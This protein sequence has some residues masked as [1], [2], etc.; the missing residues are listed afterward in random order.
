MKIP[1]VP[2]HAGAKAVGN[3]EVSVAGVT[4]TDFIFHSDFNGTNVPINLQRSVVVDALGVDSIAGEPA[5]QF[6]GL[7]TDARRKLISVRYDGRVF[8]K[9]YLSDIRRIYNVARP[10]SAS[11]IYPDGQYAIPVPAELHGENVLLQW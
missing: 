5:K 8:C 1:F 11:T 9:P 2:T 6:N 4:T 10:S 7:E 3:N